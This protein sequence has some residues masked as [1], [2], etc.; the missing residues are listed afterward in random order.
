[1]PSGAYPYDLVPY[2]STS[3]PA[4]DCRRIEVIARLFGL[5]ATPPS[6]ARV[7]ELGC[8]SAA[9]LI[10]LALDHPRASFVGCDLS[11]S[12]L[13]S[14]QRLV[15]GLDLANV[16]LRHA[17]ICEVDDGW[18]CFDYILCHDVFSWVSPSVR[19]KILTIQRCNLAPHGVGYVSCDALPGWRLHEIARDM[20]RYHVADRSD[21]RQAVDRARSIL[22]MGAAM[23][24]RHPG[25]FAELLREE[26]L[27]FSTIPDAQL[28]HLAFSPHH[29]PFYFH[30]FIQ[31]LADAGL[32]FISDSSV[33]RVPG[34]LEPATRAFLDALPRLERQQ[35]LDFLTNCTCHGALVCRR[36]A[37]ILSSPDERVLHDCWV[38]MASDTRGESVAPDPVVGEAL[39]RL[40]QRRPEFVAFSELA[41]NGSPATGGFMEA[42]AAGTLDLALAPRQLSSRITDRPMVSP[43][44]R[45]QARDGPTVTNQKCA[46]VRLTDLV[47]HVVLRLDG[48]HTRSDVRESLAREIGSGRLADDWIVRLKHDELDIERLLDDILG[49][50]RDRALLI[51]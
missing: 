37:G 15:D 30:E 5:P 10:P 8:G 50:L 4:A 42:Y 3:V 14:A 27:R 2:G 18:G 41:E 38:S 9:N 47:R 1:M 20:M 22:A 34:P 45:L 29:H 35:Y 6:H 24:D 31:A 51:A 19:Q 17:D 12:A 46:P 16:E 13:A 40:A 26:Y 23:Q 39:F 36:D 43:L 11:R 48:A 21:A 28:Y 32:Q 44:V 7:L 33:T 25:A 49:H